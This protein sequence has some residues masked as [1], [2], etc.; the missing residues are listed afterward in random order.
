VLGEKKRREGEKREGKKNRGRRK[1]K[2]DNKP[3]QH[4]VVFLHPLAAL[5]NT[6]RVE[7]R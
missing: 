5:D 2:K 1:E 4:P 3:V 7:Y 6:P